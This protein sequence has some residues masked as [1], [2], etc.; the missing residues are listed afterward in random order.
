M[1][2][3]SNQVSVPSEWNRSIVQVRKDQDPPRTQPSHTQP[4]LIESLNMQ[5]KEQLIFKLGGRSASASWISIPCNT[6]W[7]EHE[8]YSNA[9]VKQKKRGIKAGT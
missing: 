7:Q 9:K 5:P 1:E 2:Q 3:T 6:S 4:L 8:V